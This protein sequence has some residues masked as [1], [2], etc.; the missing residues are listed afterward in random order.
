MKV[1]NLYFGLK[2]V[3]SGAIKEKMASNEHLSSDA[4]GRRMDEFQNPWESSLDIKLS[5]FNSRLAS[6]LNIHGFP[7]SNVSVEAD[8]QNT[9]TAPSIEGPYSV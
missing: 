7:R 5:D 4:L 8:K 2:K 6:V 3:V 9:D 1:E